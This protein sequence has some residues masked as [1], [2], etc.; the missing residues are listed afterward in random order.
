M[1][2]VRSWSLVLCTCWPACT[3]AMRPQSSTSSTLTLFTYS[4]YCTHDMDTLTGNP[5]LLAP[6]D[7]DKTHAV[8]CLALSAAE[9]FPGESAWRR[10]VVDCQGSTRTPPTNRETPRSPLVLRLSNTGS[11]VRDSEQLSVRKKGPQT[12]KA[13]HIPD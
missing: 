6:S 13:S 11:K 5:R 7:F 10:L 2:R 3:R 1:N 9:L 12:I 4:F 8:W